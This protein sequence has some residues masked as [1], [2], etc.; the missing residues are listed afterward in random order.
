VL[1]AVWVV[2][3]MAL[4]RGYVNAIQDSIHRYRLDVERENTRVL[5]RSAARVLAGTLSGDDPE[6]ILYA[7]KM[8]ETE[9]RQVPHPAMRSLLTHEDARVRGRALA[10]LNHLGD[11]TLRT[12]A[13]ALLT[14]PDVQVR[15]EALLYLAHHERLDPLA[16]IEE[17]GDF[18]DFSI[19]AGLIAFLSRPGKMQ[20]LDAA[21]VVLDTMVGED[22]PQGVAARAEAARLIAMLP[23]E[24]GSELARLLADDTPEV[25]RPALVA[26]GTLQRDDLVK[27]ALRPLATPDLHADALAALVQVGESA[28]PKLGDYLTDAS[29]PPDVRREIPIVLAHIGTLASRRILTDDLLEPDVIMRFRVIAALN[30]LHQLHPEV[31]MDTRAIEMVLTAE[32]MGHYRSYQI[33]GTLGDVFDGDP[34]ALALKQSMDHEVERIFRLMQLRWPDQDM[35]S[36]YVGLRSQNPS[37]RANALEFLDNILQPYM[38]SLVVPLLDSQVPQQERVD[39]ANR[40][41][42]TTVDTQEQAVAALVASDDP[43]MRASGAYAIGMLK[44]TAL[45]PELDKLASSDDPLLRETVRAAR[46]KLV[47][48]PP[49]VPTAHELAAMEQTWE[50]EE[51]SM[52]IG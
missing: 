40:L 20:N 8:F 19:R 41:L 32:I 5:D 3:A 25:L 38:R 43:W 37:V 49:H 36:A 42:G 1:I 46:E 10:I 39:L 16:R 28:V 18:A 51:E 14:D 9:Q 34:V 33:L 30:K 17:L 4:R 24:F 22:G 21:R 15:T 11:R 23:D 6:Q 47:G 45:A 27:L 12:Q 50:A 48:A 44:M 52:G 31:E 7:L 13:E 2:V 35:Y 29:I 26:M